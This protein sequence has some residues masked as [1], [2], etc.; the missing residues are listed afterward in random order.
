MLFRDCNTVHVWLIVQNGCLV[1][2]R[3]SDL[4]GHSNGITCIILVAISTQIFTSNIACLFIFYLRHQT[5]LDYIFKTLAISIRVSASFL[6]ISLLH[7]DWP[8]CRL[9]NAILQL[10]AVLYFD[11]N[12]IF[13]HPRWSLRALGVQLGDV[14]VL[15]GGF[16]R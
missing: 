5:I 10:I 12:G 1:K 14:L 3:P 8:C 13:T 11:F 9:F 2:P 15:S 6:S 4:L 16:G 7:N